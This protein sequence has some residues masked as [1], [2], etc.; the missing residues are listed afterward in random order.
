VFPAWAGRFISKV[1]HAT[2]IALVDT[3]FSPGE[4]GVDH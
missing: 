1:E 4:G 2:P 3:A